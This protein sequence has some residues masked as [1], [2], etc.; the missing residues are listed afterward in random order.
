MHVSKTNLPRLEVLFLIGKW[1]SI[2]C[3]FALL[4]CTTCASAMVR[5][6]VA[7]IGM[8]SWT[9]NHVLF[10]R[11]RIPRKNCREGRDFDGWRLLLTGIFLCSAPVM[12][13]CILGIC[14]VFLTVSTRQ[15]HKRVC[16]FARSIC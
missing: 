14:Q 4:K 9:Q 16:A 7:S 3:K 2:F 11:S 10:G 8:L 1:Y 6:S 15:A 13:D 5:L 12:L